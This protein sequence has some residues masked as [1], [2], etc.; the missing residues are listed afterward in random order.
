MKRI[1][2]PMAL[3]VLA[4]IALLGQSAF[5]PTATRV[6]ATSPIYALTPISTTVAVNNQATLT[7]PAPPA[8]SYNY[9]CKLVFR[10]SQDATATA[11]NNVV[12][13]STN[14]NSFAFTVSAEDVAQKETIAE[15]DFGNPATGCAK[16]TAS[17]TATTF[18]GPSAITNAGQYWGAAYFQAP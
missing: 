5:D 12:T 6:Q 8:G 16:S 15:M 9:I 4:S 2:L 1:G 10:V 3:I 11:A 18:V 14:F 7:I 17:G 13:T